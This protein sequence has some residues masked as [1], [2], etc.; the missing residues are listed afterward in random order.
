MNVRSEVPFEYRHMDGRNSAS[1]AL[2]TVA[3]MANVFMLN[4]CYD[5]PVKLFSFQVLLLAIVVAA[6]DVPRSERFSPFEPRLPPRQR[7]TLQPLTP[8]PGGPSSTTARSMP[9][10]PL[11][12]TV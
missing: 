6:P 5:V 8:A 1:T 9:S 3:V 12:P 2:R 11:A 10:W 7:G 4:L